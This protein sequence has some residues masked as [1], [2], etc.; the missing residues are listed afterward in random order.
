[1]LRRLL[2]IV[3]VVIGALLLGVAGWWLYVDYKTS[4][5]SWPAEEFSAAKWREAAPEQRYVFYRDLAESGRLDGATKEGV[6][7]LLG[8]PDYEEPR[9]LSISYTLKYGGPDEPLFNSLY[10]LDIKLQPDG[11]L[12]S[13]A[14][15][16]D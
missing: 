3:G 9:G 8:P 10:Y 15:R 12:Q 14:V 5:R 2:Q 11:K 4:P 16:A 13:Y 7:E 1:V 6:I